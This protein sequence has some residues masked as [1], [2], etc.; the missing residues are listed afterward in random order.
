[1]RSLICLLF[2]ATLPAFGFAVDE[3]HLRGRVIDEIGKPVAAAVVDHYWRSNGKQIRTDGLPLDLNKK[4]DLKIFHGN[5]GQMEP[6]RGTT[7]AA[8]G[9]FEL[10]VTSR[11][12]S[13]IAM[14]AERKRGALIVISNGAEARPVEIKLRPLTKLQ[15]RFRLAGSDAKPD[16]TNVYV[17]TPEDPTRPIDNFRLTQCSSFEARFETWLP[18]GKYIL[19]AYGISNTKTDEIDVAVT[20]NPVIVLQGDEG[21]LDLGLLEMK[22]RPPSPRRKQMDEAKAAGS[23][24]DFTKH[25]G[26]S[27]PP[28]KV[29]D[30]RGIDKSVQLADFR[31]KW[32]LIDFWGLSCP[33]CLG[34]DLPAL[35]KLYQ[36]HA[37]KRDKFEILAFCIDSDHDI[38]KLEDLDRLLAPIE[39]H[40]WGGQK[41]PFPVLLDPTFTT[42]KSYGLWGYGQIL[43]IDPNG[44]LVPGDEKTLAEQLNR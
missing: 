17:E 5:L 32:V 34:H 26:Q 10:A 31:G 29:I 15:G 22:P 13:V 8:D 38:K 21:T 41:L 20:P 42:S 24:G 11:R 18:P 33:S 6:L 36:E 2:W 16:W 44:N 30:A 27:P 37:D 39:K 40:V 7:T 14:D 9:S 43:L 19:D 23:W 4:E 28:W 12:H 35:M 25:Y 1:M 3:W